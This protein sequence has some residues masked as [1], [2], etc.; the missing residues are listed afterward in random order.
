MG[1]HATLME[2]VSF[3]ATGCDYDTPNVFDTK[4]VAH[5]HSLHTA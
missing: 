3:H 1:T 2:H 4:L 5:L